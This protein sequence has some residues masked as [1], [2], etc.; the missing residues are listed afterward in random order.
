MIGGG[1]E[2]LTLRA[3]ARLG[4]ACNL[5]GPPEMV[6][7]KL[8]VLRRHCEAQGRNFDDIE[9][10]NLTTLLLARSDAELKAKRERL[11]LPENFWGFALTTAQAADLVGAYRDA[12]SQ[13][14]ITSFVRN[15]PE[16]QA[17]LASEVMPHFS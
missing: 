9:K 10:T 13:M 16:T 5:F 11:A 2:Q 4:D 12:G 8:A 17:L 1:G 7:Q 6:A 15:D 3:V 14:F